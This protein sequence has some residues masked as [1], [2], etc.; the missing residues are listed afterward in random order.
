VLEELNHRQR[1]PVILHARAA[2]TR[3][4][5]GMALRRTPHASRMQSAMCQLAAVE[6]TAH[7]G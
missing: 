4:Q 6:V 2:Q 3:V 5:M 1:A 7:L